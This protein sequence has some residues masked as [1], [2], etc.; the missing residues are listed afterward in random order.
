MTDRCKEISSYTGCKTTLVHDAKLYKTIFVHDAKH[1][2]VNI[3]DRSQTE[4]FL[5]ANVD[6]LA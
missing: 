5:A 3:A 2:D 1:L 6:I 4:Y